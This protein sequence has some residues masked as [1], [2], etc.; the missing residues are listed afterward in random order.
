MSRTFTPRP[1]QTQIINHILDNPFAAIFAS[2][3]M[4]KTSS[5]LTAINTLTLIDDAPVLVLAP[6][7]VALTTWLDECEKWAHLIHLKVVP[8][9]GTVAQ[10]K[11]ALTRDADIFTMNYENIPWLVEYLGKQYWPFKTVIADESTRLKSYRTRQGGKRAQQ[12]AKQLPNIERFVLLTGTPSPNGLQDLW[13]QIFFL[14]KGQRLGS[15]Y[16]AFTN[17]W[18]KWVQ[19]GADRFAG[20]FEPHSFA[21][22]QIQAKISDICLTIDAKDWFDID[23]PIET[24]IEVELPKKA[25]EMYQ[26]LEQEMFV[27]LATGD[28]IEAF[29]AASKTIKCLQLANGA[30][31]TDGGYYEVHSAKLDALESIVEEAAGMPVLVA[32]HFKSDLARLQKRFPLGKTLDSDPQTITDWNTGSIPVLFAHPASA[33]HGLNLQHGGNILAVFGHWWDLEQYQQIVERIGTVRQAQAGYDRPVYIYQIVAKGTIDNVVLARRKT[34]ADVQDLLLQ[35]MK[36][37]PNVN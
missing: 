29:N 36:E 2:M 25:Q 23:D 8:I 31:Y 15:S 20:S 34:K 27:E 37:T 14:D 5:T 11:A 16:T 10:R 3:G 1:Y 26:Q 7:R 33:G 18:F 9:I 19:K 6:K 4:G 12:L 17:R 24:V 32:Y 22:S 13:G 21:Q 30:L 28:E 35:A